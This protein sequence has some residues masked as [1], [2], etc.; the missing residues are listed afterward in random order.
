MAQKCTDCRRKRRGT[1]RAARRRG[2]NWTCGDC[3]KARKPHRTGTGSESIRRQGV[4]TLG[5]AVAAS[6]KSRN[7]NAELIKERKV[8]KDVVEELISAGYRGIHLYNRYLHVRKNEGFNAGVKRRSF[9]T[10]ASTVRVEMRRIEA[11]AALSPELTP[12]P[13]SEPVTGLDL[14]LTE[15]DGNEK[16]KYFADESKDNKDDDAEREA[17]K[18]VTAEIFDESGTLQRSKQPEGTTDVPTEGAN[19]AG[20]PDGGKTPIVASE[21]VRSKQTTPSPVFGGD[22][23]EQLK[24]LKDEYQ[25]KM[26]AADD[27][28]KMASFMVAKAQEEKRQISNRLQPRL[29]ELKQLL[30]LLSRAD[31]WIDDEG[32]ME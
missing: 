15:N 31:Q 22:R 9:D 29:L 12:A 5:D 26:D 28:I 7:A 1:S 24:H 19:A 6:D 8:N 16:L 20:L 21:A 30:D 3:I 11:K 25:G 4:F 18:T 32:V 10:I 13:K 14:L 17:V 23:I 27:A 2:G